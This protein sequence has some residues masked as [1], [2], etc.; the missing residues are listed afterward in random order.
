LAEAKE[1]LAGRSSMDIDNQDLKKLVLMEAFINEVLRVKTPAMWLLLRKTI[2]NV[3]IGEITIP[4][5]SFIRPI[6]SL[7][8][9]NPKY[10][11]DPEQ[12]IPERWID[13][14]DYN[15]EMH[16]YAYIPFSAGPRNCI[17]QHLAMIEAKVALMM[18]LERFIIE[19]NPAVR[20]EY[21][22]TFMRGFVD[23]NLVLLRKR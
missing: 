1:M 19:P 21:S 13:R 3:K 14:R 23:D 16:P 5:G 15:K 22:I 7:E 10:F 4:K 2:E 6:I 11:S 9:N 20:P 8:P 17:G 18:M 12:F